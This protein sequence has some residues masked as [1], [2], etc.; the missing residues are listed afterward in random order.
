MLSVQ[1]AKLLQ[2]YF[3][4]NHAVEIGKKSHKQ[5]IMELDSFLKL[6]YS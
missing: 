4:V 5:L 3:M 6:C 2:V 1:K